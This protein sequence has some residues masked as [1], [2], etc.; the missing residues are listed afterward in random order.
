MQKSAVEYYRIQIVR[1][2]RDIRFGLDLT[3]IRRI[4]SVKPST[5]PV[6]VTLPASG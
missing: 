3:P 6:R 1:A 2:S 5:R 4:A